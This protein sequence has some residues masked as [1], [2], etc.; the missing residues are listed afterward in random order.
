MTARLHQRPLRLWPVNGDS[1]RPPG[2]LN[3]Q[4]RHGVATEFT[5]L[6]VRHEQLIGPK[7]DSGLR[8]RARY[9]GSINVLQRSD[10]HAVAAPDRGLMSDQLPR[11]APEMFFA[12]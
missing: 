10:T 2:R 1:H 11:K 6:H 7:L 5:Q 3:D 8:P 4:M 12:D 9:R